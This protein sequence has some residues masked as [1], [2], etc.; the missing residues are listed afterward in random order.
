MGKLLEC[1]GSKTFQN[2]ELCH[3]IQGEFKKRPLYYIK[4]I[5]HVEENTLNKK[6]NYAN[7]INLFDKDSEKNLII[8]NNDEFGY[9]NNF[10][11]S[12]INCNNRNINNNKKKFNKSWEY[13][14]KEKNKSLKNINNLIIII[15]II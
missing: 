8:Y 15:K 2:L 7:K 13:K 9:D 1:G 10:N 11:Y 4:S 3:E 12:N 14:K 6:Q 5:S